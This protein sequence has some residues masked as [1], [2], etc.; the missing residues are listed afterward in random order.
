MI[1]NPF[2]FLTDSHEVSHC[3]GGHYD[4]STNGICDTSPQPFAAERGVPFFPECEDNNEKCFSVQSDTD[5]VIYLSPTPTI[6]DSSTSRYYE[7]GT[8]C[9]PLP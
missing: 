5:I 9:N 6:Q 2:D 4:V 7:I 8:V 1:T 3:N